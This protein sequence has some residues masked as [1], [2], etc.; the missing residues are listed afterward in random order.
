VLFVAFYSEHMGGGETILIRN[1][2]ND[3]EPL[4]PDSMVGVM[5]EF[6]C[7]FHPTKM[8]ETFPDDTFS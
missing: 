5:L 8:P 3:W 6:A 4:S 1:V 7:A 2:R